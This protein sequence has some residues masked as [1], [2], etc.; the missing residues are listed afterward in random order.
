MSE[1]VNDGTP[2]KK[3]R[4]KAEME[5]ARAAGEAPAKRSTKK[6]TESTQEPKKPLK[7]EVTTSTVSYHYNVANAILFNC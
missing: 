6:N 1:Q 7:P 4:T 3:R 5:A 2:K